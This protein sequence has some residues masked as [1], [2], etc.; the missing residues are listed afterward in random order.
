MVHDVRCPNRNAE[1]LMQQREPLTH[2]NTPA[3]DTGI[4]P[5]VILFGRPIRAHLPYFNRE[6]RS[7]W[8][9]INDAREKALAKRALK[10]IEPN[11]RELPP[12]NVGDSVQ[13]QNQSGNHP[14]KWHNTGVISQCLPHRQYHVLVDG[15]RRITLRSRIFL[16]RISPLIRNVRDLD[17]NMPPPR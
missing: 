14:N 12:L 11:L 10:A 4:A 2:R 7:E 5:S 1:T 6:L 16:R 13:I 8:G 15:S 17:H 3:Q 9:A